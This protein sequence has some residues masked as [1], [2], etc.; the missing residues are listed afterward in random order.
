MDKWVREFLEWWEKLEGWKAVHFI[1]VVLVLYVIAVF[2]N[3]V[4]RR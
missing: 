2:K 1:P 3:L 4:T